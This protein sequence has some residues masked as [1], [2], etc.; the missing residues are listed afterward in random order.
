[1]RTNPRPRL[2]RP[3]ILLLAVAMFPATAQDPVYESRDS[4]GRPVFSDRA[5]E[6]ARAVELRT[7]NSVPPAAITERPADDAG[8][9]AGGYAQIVIVE[10][11]D[12]AT[13]FPADGAL[14]V[15]V[16]TDPPLRD[17]DAVQILLDGE[18]AA[19][20][21]PDLQY[22][23]GELERGSHTIVAEIV[24]AERTL[25]IASDPI[26]VHSRQTVSRT[27]SEPRHRPPPAK[28]K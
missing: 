8:A 19:G 26:T 17:G 14:T 9:D 20:P 5:T 23:L 18:L 21:A 10:P 27:A 22:S 11:A 28:P 25:L 7:P 3:L 4:A 1:M 12:D 13:L 15:E 24:D 2:A 16:M 6:D